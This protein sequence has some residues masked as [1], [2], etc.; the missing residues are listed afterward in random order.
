MAL[1]F[2]ILE[3]SNKMGTVRVVKVEVGLLVTWL[4]LLDVANSRPSLQKQSQVVCMMP[5]WE[6]TGN[7]NKRQEN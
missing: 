3:S 7:N 5:V 2:M 4:L 6:T 1:M